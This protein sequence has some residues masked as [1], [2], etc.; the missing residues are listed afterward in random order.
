MDKN[1]RNEINDPQR[2]G[3]DMFISELHPTFLDGG[4]N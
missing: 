1:V 4:I 2:L 3:K